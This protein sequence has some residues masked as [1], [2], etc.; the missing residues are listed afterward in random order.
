MNKT[1]NNTVHQISEQKQ[2]ISTCSCWSF[3]QK[4]VLRR[5]KF[6]FEDRLF[7][8]NTVVLIGEGG[9]VVSIQLFKELFSQHKLEIFRGVPGH[10]CKL[11]K[12]DYILP[13]KK[14]IKIITF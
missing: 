2:P 10:P 12:L 3:T 1:F 4:P 9:G 5:Q 6:F 13:C 8:V 7:F 11:G 14:G